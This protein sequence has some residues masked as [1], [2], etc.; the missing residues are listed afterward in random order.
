MPDCRGTSYYLLRPM[1][2]VKSHFLF[3]KIFCDLHFFIFCLS[4]FSISYFLLSISDN[5]MIPLNF[6]GWVASR[7][8]LLCNETEILVHVIFHRIPKYPNLLCMY[9][10]KFEK[11]KILTSTF[12]KCDVKQ[13]LVSGSSWIWMPRVPKVSTH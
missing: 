6:L 4:S 5:Q 8:E 3:E 13:D 11:P 7:K 9:S 2:T 12:C 1:C 10:L